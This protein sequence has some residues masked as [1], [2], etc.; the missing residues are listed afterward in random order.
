MAPHCTVNKIQTYL[1][2]SSA[3]ARPGLCIL[4][5]LL[6]SL[7]AQCLLMTPRRS[8]AHVT[9]GLVPSDGTENAPSSSHLGMLALLFPLLEQPFL[10][11]TSI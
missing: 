2:S 4:I 8:S 10:A 3:S 9:V 11:L 5:I 6:L 7:W 1:P